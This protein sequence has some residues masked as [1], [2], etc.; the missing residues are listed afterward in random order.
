MVYRQSHIEKKTRNEV[1]SVLPWST[2][3]EQTSPVKKTPFCADNFFLLT[4]RNLKLRFVAVVEKLS[5]KVIY[6]ED[7][8]A[9]LYQLPPET[10]SLLGW[11]ISEG[12]LA[13][14]NFGRP[15]PTVTSVKTLY[16]F[17]EPVSTPG[18]GF[19]PPSGANGIGSG[20]SFEKAALSALGEFIE[21]NASSSYWWENKK[22]Y[23]SKFLNNSSQVNPEFFVRFTDNQCSGD[24]KMKPYSGG[25]LLHWVPAVDFCS[26][27]KID[28][29]ASLVYMYFRHEHKNEPFFHDVSSNGAATYSNYTE[30]C[31]RAVLEL[32]ER[33]VFIRFWYH[34]ENGK[35]VNLESLI[36]VFPELKELQGSLSATESLCVYDIT[37]SFGI[38]T[39][40]ATLS[41]SDTSKTAFNITAAADLNINAALQKVV[42][43]IIRF[44]EEQYPVK[45]VVPSPLE[46]VLQENLHNFAGS[47]SERRKL[48]AY[49]EMLPYLSWLEESP[50]IQYSD[51]S[52]DSNVDLSDNERYQW[53]RKKC[54]ENNLRVY[55]ADVTNSVAKHAGLHVVRALSPDII[56]VFFT[57]KYQP[58][59]TKAFTHTDQGEEIILNPVPHPFI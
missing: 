39:F 24:S 19:Y 36:S 45:K 20:A 35:K 22:L 25:Q 13:T 26:G 52:T 57:E 34:K 5:G 6:I 21:R 56:S 18:G 40:I 46:N 54:T 12:L 41:N 28:V 49:Q 29:P 43:E 31:T 51:L 33:H 4:K 55:I 58:L 9:V 53:L 23:E 14:W 32:V 59:K 7:D 37:D 50:E 15:L 30:A 47:L 48:W 10:R 8:K 38:P 16:L 44:A 42:K 2:Y 27:K 1:R 17:P 11:L 3:I